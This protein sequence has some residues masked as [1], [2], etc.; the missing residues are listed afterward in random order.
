MDQRD[1]EFVP[2][3]LPVQVGTPVQFPNSDNIRHPRLLILPGEDIRVA[4]V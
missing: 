4:V 3:V 2:Y 1:R